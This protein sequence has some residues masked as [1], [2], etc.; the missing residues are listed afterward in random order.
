[1]PT[2]VHNDET[3][4][5]IRSRIASDLRPVKPLRRDWIRS[6]FVIPY[7]LAGLGVLLLSLGLRRDAQELGPEILWG[8]AV[9]EFLAAYLIVFVALRQAVPGNTTSPRVWVG[10]PLLALALQS[11]VAWWSYQ[12]SPLPVPPGQTLRY[13]MA[14]FGLMSVFGLVPLALSLWLLS[15]GLPLRPRIA[16]LL[17][18]F[19][20]GL[21]AEAI[22]RSH[23]PYSNLNHV[24]TWHGGAILMLGLM[25]FC[26]GV[27]WESLRAR[28]WRTQNDTD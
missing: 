9:L 3:F 10:L 15:R 26:C 14:C 4:D 27:W 23:C 16:G 11:G 18:G 28:R 13:G 22:Y 25:G 20:G 6:L 1:M 19:G 17:A 7:A 2:P 24:I 12:S 21:V 8:L 5:R